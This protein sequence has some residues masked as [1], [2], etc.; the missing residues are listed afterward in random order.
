MAFWTRLTSSCAKNSWDQLVAKT[1]GPYSGCNVEQFTPRACRQTGSQTDQQK[2]CRTVGAI[3]KGFSRGIV[4][5]PLSTEFMQIPPLWSFLVLKNGL[6]LASVEIFTP[7]LFLLR[8]KSSDVLTSRDNILRLQ[9]GRT[10]LHRG[11][12]KNL[13]DKHIFCAALLQLAGLWIT[14]LHQIST[15]IECCTRV[16]PGAA[17]ETAFNNADECSWADVFTIIVES[18]GCWAC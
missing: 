8:H 18:F 7:C 1:C 14:V 10:F 6:Y 12:M 5:H 9:L 3:T 13:L 2:F 17:A 11:L 16:D 15:R 4:A